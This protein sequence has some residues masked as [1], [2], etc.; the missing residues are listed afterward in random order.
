MAK[1]PKAGIEVGV[2]D[3]PAIEG[4]RNLAK[5]FGSFSVQAAASLQI[6]QA[7]WSALTGAI[8]AVVDVTSEYVKLAMEQERVERRAVA[9]IQ[10]RQTFTREELDLL[11]QANAARQQQLGIGDEVQLQLQGTMAAMGVAKGQLDAAT[12]AAIG[13]S[14]AMGM[15]LEEASKIA[16]KAFTGNVAALAKY[17]VK[18]KSAADAQ[19]Q[20]NA[21]FDVAA[22]N[23]RSLETRL[24]VLNA[25]VGDFKEVL[26]GAV[27]ESGAL[28]EG[29]DAISVAVLDLQS[30]FASAEGREAV[31][32]FFGII[33]DLAGDAINAMLGAYKM[34]QELRGEGDRQGALSRLGGAAGLA[35]T[36][37]PAGFI[38]S[39]FGDKSLLQQAREDLDQLLGRGQGQDVRASPMLLAFEG[40]ADNLKRAALAAREAK[41]A[42]LGRG[43]AGGGRAGG[44]DIGQ[45]SVTIGEIKS[46][47][48]LQLEAEIQTQMQLE[49]GMR[50]A[51]AEHQVA[52]AREMA[53]IQR[54][55]D[56]DNLERRN[57]LHMEAHALRMQTTREMSEQELQAIIEGGKAINDAQ[58]AHMQSVAD[59][60][61]AVTGVVGQAITD[62]IS[63]W[64]S[65]ADM[66][67]MTVGKFA[68]AIIKQLGM[69]MLQTGI[70]ALLLAPLALIP[71][72]AI[73][74]G[75][76]Q[77]APILAAAGLGLTVAGAGAIA[78][79]ARMGGGA[80]GGAASVPRGGSAGGGAGAPRGFDPVPRGFGGARGDMAAAPSYNVNVSFG[81][82]GDERRAAR[83]IRD[84]LERGR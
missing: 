29:I 23:S 83:M 43:G 12:R 40:L 17:G 18:A 7:G 69:M 9:A 76:P 78:L 60:A 65:G 11:Q 66:A 71:G 39:I 53:D 20:L 38:R 54:Q 36:L 82:V 33:L 77:N 57:Q 19:E 79:G 10:A 75:G 74:T 22:A 70:A 30:Y 6:A 16:G 81:V 44:E 4:L 59:V 47:R 31:N 56:A 27:T 13:L 1:N 32:G 8:T 34:V 35:T 15:G 42:V 62:L 68:G 2:N 21:L 5:S 28:K 72:L 24:N 3:R 80:G 41:G 51:A 61:S 37:S 14:E 55:V 63:A 45:F 25:N 49:D 58:A 64:A 26:G 84:V 67:D 73:L 46:S 50:R 48:L 52:L